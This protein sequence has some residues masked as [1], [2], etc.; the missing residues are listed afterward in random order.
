MVLVV[1]TLGLRG[2]KYKR[3]NKANQPNLDNLITVRSSCPLSHSPISSIYD[4]TCDVWRNVW[5][6]EPLPRLNQ[7]NFENVMVKSIIYVWSEVSTA[8]SCLIIR[9]M[10]DRTNWEKLVP[11]QWNQTTCPRWQTHVHQSR[12]ILQVLSPSSL[13]CNCKWKVRLHYMQNRTTHAWFVKTMAIHHHKTMNQL[14][15]QQWNLWTS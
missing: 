9:W 5:M 11:Q 7:C 2:S 10:T 3:G 13:L 14:L 6:M 8:V 4:I 1:K 12:V 15:Y